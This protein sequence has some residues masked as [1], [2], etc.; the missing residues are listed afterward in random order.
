[1]RHREIKE[2]KGEQECNTFDNLYAQE[3]EEQKI[4]E[5]KHTLKRFSR[6]LA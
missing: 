3:C 2:I 6:S 1:M 4:N 5:S